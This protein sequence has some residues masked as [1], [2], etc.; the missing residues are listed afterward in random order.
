[1]HDS[2][3]GVHPIETAVRPSPVGRSVSPISTV[4]TFLKEPVVIFSLPR[5]IRTPFRTPPRAIHPLRRYGLACV[6]ILGCLF[7]AAPLQAQWTLT[8]GDDFTG[9]A[10]ASYDT[11]KWL[12]E[13]KHNTGNV[14][15][16]GTIQSTT[17]SRANSY[18]DGNGNLIVAMTYDAAT[19]S[20]S[21]A[22]LKTT[23][24]YDVG[25]YGKIEARVQNPSAVG[26]GAALWS[27]GANNY[28][29]GTPWPWCGE[30]DI[31]EIQAKTAGHNGSTIHGGQTDGGTFYEYGGISVPVDLPSGQSFDNSFHVFAVQW[32][33]YHL[34]YLLDGQPYGDVYLNSI[35]ATDQWPMEQAIDLI[36]SSGVGGNGGT[37]N[38]QGF[39]SNMTVDYV[40]YSRLSA[41]AP[42]PVTALTAKAAS[43]NAINLSWTASTTSGVTYDI[44]A[45][46]T[47]NAA[48]SIGNLVAASVAGTSYQHQGLQ[49]ATPYYYTVKAANFGGESSAATANV[50]TQAAGN[51]SQILLSAGGYAA[52]NYMASQFVIGG[53]TNFHRNNAVDTSKV[54][55]PAPQQV[56]DTERFGAAAWTI[57]GLTSGALYQVRTHFVESAHNAAGQRAFNLSVNSQTVLTNFDIFAAAGA[58]NRAVVESFNTKADEYGIVEVQTTPGTSSAGDLNPTIA[59]ID[60]LPTANNTNLVGAAPGNETN[61]SINSGGGAAGTFVADEEFNGGDTA[62]STDTINTAGVANAAPAAVYQSQRY[63]P[64]TYVLTGLVANATYNVRMHF[65]ETYS[66]ITGNGQRVFNVNINGQPALTNFDIYALAPGRDKALVENYTTKA[67]MFGQI[68]VQLIYGGAQ[69]PQI[70]GL[71]VIQTAA[72]TTPAA[73]SQL[74]GTASTGQIALSWSASTTSGVTY[75]VYR[76][77]SGAAATAI[78]TGLTTT[79]YTDTTVVAG[80]TYT[81]YVVAVNSGGTSPQ[82]NQLTITAAGSGGGTS[83]VQ[84]DS[85]GSAAVGTYAADKDYDTGGTYSTTHA[86]VVPTGDSASQAVYQTM[87]QGVFTYTI[88]GFTA[89]STHTVKLHFAELYF[90]TAGSRVFNVGINGTTVLPNFDIVKA[91]G[92]AFT[93]IV[94]S[95]T[96]TANSSGQVVVGFTR[97]TVDQPLV[98]AIDVQ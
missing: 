81:Y 79:S 20:Y 49:P 54:T 6:A 11:T 70:N 17:D 97:G 41:G 72:S 65:A 75:S 94:E 57:T 29:S 25:P 4:S 47:A 93:A 38:G 98:N 90:S 95:F 61:L 80:I 91:T 53:S 26:M 8:W 84:I 21:S 62:T 78:K 32:A 24:R 16:D 27:L 33:P 50:P 15:G 44:Y 28:N 10:G 30:L 60:I 39:P 86:I 45:S 88:P 66:G 14:W 74:T 42:V 89:G 18:L 3:A 58:A 92:A 1:M 22:R 12:N 9:N 36:L 64:F 76:G 85:G 63:V 55:N 59:A 7:A 73:P 48:P 23:G 37:P 71:E 56:Y 13:V 43:S 51:S 31:M 83:A 5:Q 82:S 67:D 77:T 52:A 46:T 69:Q 19:N 2:R 96:A 87:R 40:H 34:Q 35:G 68:I